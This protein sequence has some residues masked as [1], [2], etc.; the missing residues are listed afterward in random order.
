MIVTPYHY[1]REPSV[2]M[3]FPDLEMMKYEV[4]EQVIK[5]S[6]FGQQ[7]FYLTGQIRGENIVH[8]EVCDEINNTF[9]FH[10]HIFLYAASQTYLK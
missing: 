7:T 3:F 5:F 10:M 4:R 1:D 2:Y 6:N 9:G 8:G